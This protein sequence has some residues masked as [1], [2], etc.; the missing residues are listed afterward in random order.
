MMQVIEY[1]QNEKFLGMVISSSVKM[2]IVVSITDLIITIL[3]DEKD[4]YQIKD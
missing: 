2:R 3:M 1:F 4:F